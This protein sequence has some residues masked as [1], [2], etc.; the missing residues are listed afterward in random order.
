MATTSSGARSTTAHHLGCSTWIGYSAASEM[1]SNYS[2]HEEIS[3]AMCPRVRPGAATARLPG[4]ISSSRFKEIDLYSC[5]QEILRG[6]FEQDF[7][8]VFTNSLF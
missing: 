7:P 8:D 5:R 4:T 6:E 3:S 2:P 1:H